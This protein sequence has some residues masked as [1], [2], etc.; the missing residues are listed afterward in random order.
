MSLWK[1]GDLLV[2]RDSG[3]EEDT[4]L[5]LEEIDAMLNLALEIVVVRPVCSVEYILKEKDLRMVKQLMNSAGGL[6]LSLATSRLLI[7]LCCLYA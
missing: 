1:R 7:R 5:L 6:V 4:A 2:R 3:S